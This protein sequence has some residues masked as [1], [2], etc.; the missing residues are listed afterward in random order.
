[1]QQSEASMRMERAMRSLPVVAE[2]FNIERDSLLRKMEARAEEGRQLAIMRFANTKVAAATE[3]VLSAAQVV[4]THRASFLNELRAVAGKEFTGMQHVHRMVTAFLQKDLRECCAGHARPLVLPV[5][6]TFYEGHW[7]Y[8]QPPELPV[9]DIEARGSALALQKAV[10]ELSRDSKFLFSDF[11]QRPH[12]GL[13]VVHP[14]NV[15]WAIVVRYG[16]VLERAQKEDFDY[17]LSVVPPR[18]EWMLSQ[19]T[20]ME[21]SSSV[22]LSSRVL[23][24]VYDYVLPHVSGQLPCELVS[25]VS[26]RIQNLK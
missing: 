22:P 19:R 21:D 9:T 17:L 16:Q 18:R 1:M 4:L 8:Q 10:D 25:T 11:P 2:T 23:A 12:Q 6:A 5:V 24:Y 20:L 15:C 13:A 26:E 3:T 7:A 14:H